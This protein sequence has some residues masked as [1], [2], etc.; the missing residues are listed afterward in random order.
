MTDRTTSNPLLVALGIP[1]V[2][3][4]RDW[5]AGALCTQVGGD[6]FFPILGESPAPARQICRECPVC[7]SCLPAALGESWGVWAGTTARERSI[8]R[9]AANKASTPTGARRQWRKRLVELAACRQEPD[10]Q[11]LSQ[12]LGCTEDAA[13]RKIRACRTTQTHTRTAA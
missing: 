7:A 10:L 1:T 6:L 2:R 9:R 4:E 3:T 12:Q 5:R 8:L 11:L 13:E